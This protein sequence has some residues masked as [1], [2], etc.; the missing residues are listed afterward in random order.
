MESTQVDWRAKMRPYQIPSVKHR[1]FLNVRKDKNTKILDKKQKF[2]Q[3]PSRRLY[4]ILSGGYF[5]A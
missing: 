3:P 5:S 2:I 1:L 4:L